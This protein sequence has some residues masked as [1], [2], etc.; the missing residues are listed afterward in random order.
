MA[1]EEIYNS[2]FVLKIK[3]FGNVTI[4]NM[5]LSTTDA[6]VFSMAGSLMTVLDLNPSEHSDY[7]VNR[8][9]YS[10]ITQD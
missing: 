6:H 2:K 7:S 5:R 8:Y 4:P 1:T 10:T 9:I 3:N